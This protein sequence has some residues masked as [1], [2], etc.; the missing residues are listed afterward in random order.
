MF[1]AAPLKQYE[2]AVL[3]DT[4]DLTFDQAKARLI[5]LVEGA[6]KQRE[7]KTSF[8]SSFRGAGGNSP[9]GD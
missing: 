1:F 3:L 4:T 2:D 6:M 5:A 8:S 7:E 9:R